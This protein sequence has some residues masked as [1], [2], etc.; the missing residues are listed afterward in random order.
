MNLQFIPTHC[1]HCAMRLEMPKPDEAKTIACTRCV[2]YGG[3]YGY[4]AYNFHHI[5]GELHFLTILV[6]PYRIHIYKRLTVV[7]HYHEGY[8]I[9]NFTESI[10]FDFNPNKLKRMIDMMVIFK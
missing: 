9:L 3:D 7:N 10:P 2:L 5:S 6:K 8:E 4:T 1:V